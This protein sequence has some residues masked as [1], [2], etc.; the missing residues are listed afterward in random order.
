VEVED[1][2]PGEVDRARVDAALH[3]LE[4]AV[5]AVEA[6]GGIELGAERLPELALEVLGHRDAGGALEDH[7]E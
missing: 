3:L 5:L 4:P 2:E 7:S 6:P 1:A